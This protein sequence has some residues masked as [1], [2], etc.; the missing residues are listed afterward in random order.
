[1]RVLWLPTVLRQAG[2]TVHTYP[3]WQTR[4]SSR[5]GE[6]VGFGPL[7]GV[8]CHATAGSRN[9]S[10]TGEMRVLWETGSPSAPAPISQLY[11][12][13]SGVWTVGASGRCNHVLL[14]QKG[15]HRGFG[16]YQLI[17]VEAGND[18]RG[19]PWPAA[20]LDAY[21]R[22]V[23]AI[24]R[25][26]SWPAGVVVAHREHQDGKS[27]PAGIN[28]SAFR[29]RVAELIEEDEVSWSEGI[30]LP[31]FAVDRWDDWTDG[32]A[33]AGGLLASGYA[34]SRL[35][36]EL[37]RDT[38]LEQRAGFAA[39]LAKLDGKTDG[40]IAQ[41]V[42]AEVGRAADAERAERAAEAQALRG[43]FTARLDAAAQ[44]RAELAELIRQVQSGEREAAEV[45]EEMGRRLLAAGDGTAPA[46]D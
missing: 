41:I 24:C 10:D 39:V 1:M 18:N 13:R 5:W 46:G 7:R 32:T 28:M 37:A 9:S 43:E 17:G 6:E 33:S 15:P 26:M 23:A 27:D 35:G 44:E 16:N 22:G 25:H 20:Q 2:L 3:G 12:S 34:H 30:R 29:A 21:R 36:G 40:E 14:G 19:E 38:L 31:K 42:R 45:V 8:V 4:G 11:L